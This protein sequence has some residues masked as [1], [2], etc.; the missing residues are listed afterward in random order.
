MNYQ[1]FSKNNRTKTKRECNIVKY[2]NNFDILKK[3]SKKRNVKININEII[4]LDKLN[5]ELIQKK[6]I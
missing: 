5:R 6:K 4:Q 2:K 1:Y 3:I